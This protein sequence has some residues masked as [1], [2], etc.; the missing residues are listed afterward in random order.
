M[1]AEPAI[2]RVDP[3]NPGRD[4]IFAAARA[5]LRGGVVVFPTTGLYGLAADA[6][7]PGAVDRV[8]SLKQRPLHRPVLV[9]VNEREDV[10]PL[11]SEVP[12]AA[13]LLMNRLW[14]GGLTLV[15]PVHPEY[16]HLTAGTG[17]IGV[18]MAA[19]PVA[20]ALVAAAG[21]PITGTSANISGMP[22]VSRIQDLSPELAAGAEVLLDAGQ[23]AGGKGSTV[24]DATCDP[25]AVL[26]EGA[27]TAQRIRDVLRG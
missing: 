25:V 15:L 19:H 20:R 1:D 22:A 11:V 16:A 18:R 3:E 6:R 13:T 2:L 8:F 4:A 24:V 7:G 12:S 21:I 10:A 23:L 9:L 17:K 27:V 26:R 14:P 5:V